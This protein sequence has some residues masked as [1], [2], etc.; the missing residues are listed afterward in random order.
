MCTPEITCLI[1]VDIQ[2]KLLP[3]MAEP[4]RV[5]K[6]TG[7]MIQIAEALDLPILWCQQVP[8]A[9]GPTANALASLLEGVEPIEK[10]SFSCCG[11][12]DFTAK[13]KQINP[14]Q[15]ILCGI[16][17]H[18]CVFQTAADLIQ[19]G[20]DV[21]VVAD[22]TSSRT[23]ENKQIGIDRMRQQGAIITS[24]EM[25]LFELLKDAKHEKFREL[26]KLIK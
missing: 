20:L 23:P 7:I 6:N 12:P 10:S 17:S 24:V 18:V 26:A 5:I 21:Y 16:E 14:E 1:I 2:E 25:C 11:E 22:A 19:E 8:K 9:L 3:V 15:A 13:L 4:Q